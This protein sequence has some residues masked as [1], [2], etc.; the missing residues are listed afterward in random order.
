[1]A[2]NEYLKAKNGPLVWSFLGVNIALLLAIVLSGKADLTSLNAIWDQMTVKDGLTAIGLPVLA[3]ILTG[4][5]G[6]IA[7]ARIVFWRITDSL[8]G[9]RAFSHFVHSDPRIDED[10]LGAKLGEF[11][12]DP[13]EQNALWY[14]LYKKHSDKLTVN[15][16][17]RT[18]LLTRDLAAVSAVLICL[19]AVAAGLSDATWKLQLGYTT[20][21]VLQYLVTAAAGRNYGN[22]FVTNV[23][24]EES[25]L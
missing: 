21:L 11:P 15:E 9:Y 1:M 7:K 3:I 18:Y 19:F 22:R 17:H 25:L 24:V 16:A 20:Y 2:R 14:K 8:P 4:V 5:L 23:L 13:K 12:S 10:S 6:D